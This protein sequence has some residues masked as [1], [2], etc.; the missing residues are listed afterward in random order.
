MIIRTAPIRNLG[1]RCCVG[2]LLAVWFIN[3]IVWT[4]W[5][6]DEADISELEWLWKFFPLVVIPFFFLGVVFPKIVRVWHFSVIF[7]F[8]LGVPMFLVSITPFAIV[9]CKIDNVSLRILIS[10]VFILALIATAIRSFSRTKEK[11]RVSKYLERQLK[12]VG[13]YYYISRDKSDDFFKINPRESDQIFGKFWI[14]AGCILSCLGVPLQR[15]LVNEFG[16]ISLLVM[17]F[18]LLLP[19]SFWVVRMM[20][21][22]LVLWI[23]SIRVFEKTEMSKV[24]LLDD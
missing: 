13:D 14:G 4:Q 17:A 24:F 3:L 23:F 5:L 2:W 21:M 11:V 12:R 20:A 7:G 10:M 15:I 22:S 18:A 8:G 9:V 6:Y 19:V 1:Y 16:V